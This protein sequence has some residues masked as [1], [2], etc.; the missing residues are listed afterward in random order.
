MSELLCVYDYDLDFRDPSHSGTFTI[1]SSSTYDKVKCIGKKVFESIS[2]SISNFV[3]GGLTAGAGKGTI[4]GSAIK[5]K[6]DNNKIP[7]RKEDQIII[8]V[9]DTVSPYGTT[10]TTVY[11]SDAGQTKVKAE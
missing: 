10:T 4:T 2:F 6:I 1:T 9:T 7:I 8:T 5:I 3:G 11:V